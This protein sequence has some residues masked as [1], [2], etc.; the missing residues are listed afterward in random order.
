MS[1]IGN[2]EHSGPGEPAECRL[3]HRRIG[4]FQRALEVAAITQV[5]DP[6]GAERVAEQAAVGLDGQD[7][8][9]I[10]IL[11]A[12]V[13]EEF[14]AGGLVVA[15]EVARP[16]QAEMELGRSLNLGV[17]A[18]RNTARHRRQAADGGRDLLASILII[19]SADK[20]GGHKQGSKDQQQ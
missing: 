4:V 11:L 2:L 9:K 14:R 19:S 3:D 20:N 13:G 7:A 16:G 1:G 17:D 5:E 10:G 6:A 15:V 18:R 8:G 12:N